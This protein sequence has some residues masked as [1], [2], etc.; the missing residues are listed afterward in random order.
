[1]VMGGS[2]YSIISGIQNEY[3]G[4]IVKTSYLKS[5]PS[6]CS[7]KEVARVFPGHGHSPGRRPAGVDGTQ[8]LGP[9]PHDVSNVERQMS[10]VS[11]RGLL[12][13]TDTRFHSSPARVRVPS[14]L[15]PTS[16][17]CSSPPL[18]LADRRPLAHAALR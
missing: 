4:F 12:T 3:K 7:P 5:Y 8:H 16:S 2:V 10:D 11:S 9:G 13:I 1:M 6:S 17:F 14:R 18:P 15:P